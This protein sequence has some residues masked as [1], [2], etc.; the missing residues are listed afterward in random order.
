[1]YLKI[2]CFITLFKQHNFCK[3]IKNISYINIFFTHTY[4]YNILL[5]YY[6]KNIYKEPKIGF[7][8]SI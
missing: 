8:I 3:Y 1:M 4:V 7:F 2:V 5:N 6:L